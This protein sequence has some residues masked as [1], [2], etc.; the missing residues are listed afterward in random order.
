MG[1]IVGQRVGKMGREWVRQAESGSNEQR[2]G[3]RMGQT[4]REWI[5]EWVRQEESG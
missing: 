4:G 5:R 1:Q 2:V 3:Q